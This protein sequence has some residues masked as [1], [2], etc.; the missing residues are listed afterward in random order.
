MGCTRFALPVAL[1]GM[2]VATVASAGQPSSN[3]RP[4]FNRNVN[5]SNVSNRSARDVLRTLTGEWQGQIEVRRNDKVSVSI[6][7]ASNRFDKDG[8]FVSAFSGFAFGRMYDGGIRY[9][10]ERDGT[11]SSYACTQDFNVEGMVG[12]F[13][14]GQDGSLV[15]IGQPTPNTH[16]NTKTIAHVTSVVN[17][18]KYTTEWYEIGRNGEK[19]SIVKMT[20]ER[21]GRGQQADASDLFQNDQFQNWNQR[22][23]IRSQRTAEVTE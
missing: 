21:L 19:A 15:A 7:S 3:T 17:P 13:D 23:R 9:E 18:N 14:V 1:I 11:A 2:T 8:N 20:F 5:A 6:V 16:S 12:S 22:V 4:G 10:I